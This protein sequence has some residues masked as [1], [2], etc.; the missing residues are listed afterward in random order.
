MT[1]NIPCGSL[2]S[3]VLLPEKPG[4]IL[5][6]EPVTT[7][8][9]SLGR[10]ITFC[11]LP[12]RNMHELYKDFIPVLLASGKVVW[13]HPDWFTDPKNAEQGMMRLV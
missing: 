13:M 4:P 2:W 9:L 6:I 8:L 10:S 11:V 1:I 12:Q 7:T 5:A 3:I